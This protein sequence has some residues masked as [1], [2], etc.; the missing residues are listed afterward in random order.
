MSRGSLVIATRVGCINEKIENNVNGFLFS[1]G[2]EKEFSNIIK[3]INQS[4]T[5][6]FSIRKKYEKII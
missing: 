2:N 4:K 3:Q 1:A 6:C 5:D